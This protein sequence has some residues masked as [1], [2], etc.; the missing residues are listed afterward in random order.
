MIKSFKHIIFFFALSLWDIPVGMSQNWL[1][2]DKGID[3]AFS[4]GKVKNIVVDPVADKLY[5]SGHFYYNGDCSPMRGVARWTGVSWVPVGS[6]VQGNENKYGLTIYKDTLYLSGNFN[7]TNVNCFV[8]KWNGTYWD[9]IPNSP[10]FIFTSTEKDGILY[11]AGPF[12]NF[13][14]DSTFMIQKY[15]GSQFSGEIPYCFSGS[16]GSVNAMAF[17]QDTLYIGG[18]Y[19]MLP[20]KALGSLGK[21]DGTD[22]QLVSPEFANS[23]ANCNIQ[24]MVEYKGELY[25]GGYFKQANGYA[26]NYIMKWNGTSFSSVGT[27]MNSWV[28]CMKVYNDKLYVGGEFTQAGGV[29]SNYVAMWDG[30]NWN[31]ITTDTFALD[32]GT[33]IS[34]EAINV[35]HDSLIIGGVFTSI[36]GDTTCRKIAKYNHALTD[37][38]SSLSN[39]DFNIF[40]NPATNQI[41]IEFSSSSTTLLEIKNVLGQTIYSETISNIS[42]IHVKNIDL[43]EFSNG[44]YIVRVQ[45]ENILKSQKFIKQ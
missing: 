34:V 20:C 1:P 13:G 27:G 36:N 19:Y 15:D 25:M 43:T 12:D 18:Y 10:E 22:L 42:D 33:S 5:I 16:G 32:I 38:Q 31:S 24:A 23:G 39:G 35:Y 44:V 28:R 40:P 37:N 26:G 4:N 3:C 6:G 7:S 41:T 14:G 9:T 8:A 17:Y 45:S 2:M 30:T 21:W 29:A 11:T